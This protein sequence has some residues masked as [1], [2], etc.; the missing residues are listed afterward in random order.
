LKQLKAELV[1][2][3]NKD[4]QDFVNLSTNL[5]GVDKDINELKQPLYKIENQVKVSLLNI[6]QITIS[7]HEQKGC[8]SSFP[9]SY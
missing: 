5:K 4:Y 2:L 6:Y 9:T 8:T 7:K 3:I 1:E